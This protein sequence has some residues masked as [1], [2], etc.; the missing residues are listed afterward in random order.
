LI[1]FNWRTITAA[2][3]FLLYLDMAGNEG[4]REVINAG[5]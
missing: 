3:N 1:T 5:D 2:N 4:K